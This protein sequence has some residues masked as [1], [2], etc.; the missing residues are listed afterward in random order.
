[1]L[2]PLISAR[3]APQS[4]AEAPPN[5][6][7]IVTDDQRA[8]LEVMPDTLKWFEAGGTRYT[9][10]FATTPTCCPSRASLLTGRYVHNHGVDNRKRATVLDQTTTINY[11]LQRAGY[12]TGLFGKYLNTWPAE[13]SPPHWNHFAFFSNT[14]AETYVGDRWNVQGT[15]TS[16]NQYA[17]D[18]IGGRAESFIRDTTQPWLLYLSTPNPH[19]PWT[20]EAE[21]ENAPVGTWE[22]NPAVFETDKS[23][24]PSYVQEAKHTFKQGKTLRRRQL[25]TLY[26]VDDM[27]ERVF[28]ALQDTGE[29]DNTLAFFISD[30]GLMWG[31]HGRTGKSVPYLQ[32]IGVPMFARW[33]GHLSAGVED[34]RLV[35]N[36]DVAPTALQAAGITQLN[37][38]IDGRSLLGSHARERILTEFFESKSNAP[39][40]SSTVTHEYQYTEYADG[41]NEYYDL[42]NDQWQLENLLNNGTPGDEPSNVAELA[43]QL[44]ADRACAGGSCP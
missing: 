26:S 21:Y 35:A 6:L 7:I 5:I 18:Y 10:A 19:G 31:E 13:T 12:R 44:A 28:L 24:K 40:W 23:D 15:L 1:M 34:S 8:G 16:V 41:F 14:T 11:Y 37:A 32:A 42:T 30:N 25:R 17:T 20:A 3:P 33:P 36:I 2:L 27:V 43:S 4:G 38:P 39:P 22:G 29:L 9:N